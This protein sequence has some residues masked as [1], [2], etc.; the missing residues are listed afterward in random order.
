MKNLFKNFNSLKI[1]ITDRIHTVHEKILPLLK[2]KDYLGIF[3]EFRNNNIF[4]RNLDQ[5]SS[6]KKVRK[7]SKIYSKLNNNLTFL[8]KSRKFQKE[9]VQLRSW[10]FKNSERTSD[11]R[12]TF[13]LFLLYILLIGSSAF[14]DFKDEDVSFPTSEDLFRPSVPVNIKFADNMEERL[15]NVKGIDEVKAEIE[16]IVKMLKDPS[17]YE[18]AGAKLIRGILL[19]GKPG[20]GKTLMAKA[21][22]GESGC[23]FIYCNAAEFDQSLV[24]AGSNALKR[25]F[26]AARNNTPC[27]I[28]I[29]EID[30]LLHKGRRSG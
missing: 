4:E 6:D 15:E 3:R 2:T 30:S 22:A 18:D 27:I 20:T 17:K 7:V 14:H 23:N 10:A 25:I 5:Y 9:L 1:P 13:F 29:D 19:I 24:G 26:K 12:V 11:L 16:E 21:L 28:F 8:L